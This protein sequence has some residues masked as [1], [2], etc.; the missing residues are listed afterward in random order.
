VSAALNSTGAVTQKSKTENLPLLGAK[1]LAD[2]ASKTKAALSDLR[3]STELAQNLIERYGSLTSEVVSLI[4]E[5]PEYG[6]LLPGADTVLVAEV[7]YAVKFEDARHLEDVLVR[8]T[9][10]SIESIN[11]G[12]TAAPLVAKIMARLLGWNSKQ[13]EN[14]LSRYRTLID[15]EA[16]A[17]KISKDED[18]DAVL[19]KAPDSISKKLSKQVA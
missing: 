8:R 16:E 2:A 10:L 5:Y 17:S 9:R 14:E 11:S 12:L 18:A 6:K 3:I 7:A 13:S 15:L 4:R 19:R 1:G